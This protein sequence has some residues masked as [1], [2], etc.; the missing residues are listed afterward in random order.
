M[1]LC[2]GTF[3]HKDSSFLEKVVFKKRLSVQI[4]TDDNSYGATLVDI[5]HDRSTPT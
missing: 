5:V 1:D 2:D 3:R 4:L